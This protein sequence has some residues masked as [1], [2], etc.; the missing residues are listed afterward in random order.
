MIG[1]SLKVFAQY[2]ALNIKFIAD[3]WIDENQRYNN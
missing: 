1:N 2:M 3:Y